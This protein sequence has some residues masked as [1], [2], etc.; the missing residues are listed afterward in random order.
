MSNVKKQNAL[1]N[2]LENT[3]YRIEE[4]YSD[5]CGIDTKCLVLPTSYPHYCNDH[6]AKQTGLEVK[7]KKLYAFHRWYKDDVLDIVNGEWSLQPPKASIEQGS[8][9]LHIPHMGVWIDMSKSNSCM[10]RWIRHVP[11]PNVAFVNVKQH[12]IDTGAAIAIKALRMI[13]PE[14]EIIINAGNNVRLAF[15]ADPSSSS[16]SSSS[17]SSCSPSSSSSS[18]ASLSISSSP[19]ASSCLSSSSSFSSSS[20]YPSRALASS[21][22]SLSASSSSSSLSSSPFVVLSNFHN[23]I[24]KSNIF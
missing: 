21:G 4:C 19:S 17:F 13:E 22:F 18:S 20:T 10:A 2:C 11:N 5:C 16:S 24:S 12:S 14:E 3:K 15:L 8:Y 9:L 6:N 7:E 1:S 23:G